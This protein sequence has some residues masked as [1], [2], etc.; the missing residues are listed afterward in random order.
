M[1]QGD[2]PSK[3]RYSVR[4]NPKIADGA[5][6]TIS[7]RVPKSIKALF[8]ERVEELK[9]DP[10]EHGIDNQTDAGQDAIVKW[11]LLEGK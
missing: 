9:A 7:F 6:A 1:G 5:M 2:D 11:L 8:E 10:E 3:D 4:A